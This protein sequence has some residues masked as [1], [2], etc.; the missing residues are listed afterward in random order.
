MVEGIQILDK[1][2][3]LEK[4]VQNKF[5]D[6]IMIQTMD[7]LIQYEERS[8]RKELKKLDEERK[9]FEKKHKMDSH[10]FHT[11]FHNGEIGDETDFFEWDALCEMYEDTLKRLNIL[12]GKE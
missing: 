10:I 2:H 11:K 7:K 5:Y 8:Q 6:E 3:N 1:I 9:V 4:L 12:K